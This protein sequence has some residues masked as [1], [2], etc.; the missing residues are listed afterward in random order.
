MFKK[1]RDQINTA[2]QHATAQAEQDFQRHAAQFQQDAARQGYDIRPQMP[3]HDMAAQAYQTMN[4]DP[5]MA[6]FLALPAQEQ[7]RQQHVANAYGQELRR[8]HETG[9]PAT[10]VIRTL[11]P[12]GTMVVGQQQYTSLLDVTRADGVTYQ[13]TITHL[14]PSM[15]FSQYTPGTRHQVR[16]DPGN[17]AN[18]AVFELIA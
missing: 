1:I 11:D 16:I 18:V 7:L 3:T 10:A 17:P 12:T 13:T 6:A 14:V 4:Q 2:T 5:G 8:L 9:H 15:T